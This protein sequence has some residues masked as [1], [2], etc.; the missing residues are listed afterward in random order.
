MAGSYMEL[1]TLALVG[2]TTPHLCWPTSPATSI[3]VLAWCRWMPASACPSRCSRA[4]VVPVGEWK[5]S[6]GG[7]WCAS[8]KWRGR[9][10]W[11]TLAKWAEAGVCSTAALPVPAR[12]AIGAWMRRGLVGLHML[13]RCWLRRLESSG[14]SVATSWKITRGIACGGL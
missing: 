9:A 7:A 10:S 11:S 1:A 13:L 14:P 6:G 3:A 12:A 2:R 8:C 4:R 5:A